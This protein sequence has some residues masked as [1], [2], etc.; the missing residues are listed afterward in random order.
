VPDSAPPSPVTT[1]WIT[2]VLRQQAISVVTSGTTPTAVEGRMIYETDTDALR[3]YDGGGWVRQYEGW[4]SYTPTWGGITIG[5]GAST[6]AY[7]R[8]GGNCLFVARLVL[9]STTMTGPLT[10]NPP[11]NAGSAADLDVCKVVFS[12][13]SATA[14]SVGHAAGA[15]TSS[16]SLWAIN[17]AGTY[18]TTAAITTTIPF[19]WANTDIVF[20]HGEYRMTTRYS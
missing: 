13:T 12:D 18:L 6:G 7:V 1:S 5:S 15:S 19:T 3:L 11:I 2:T 4:Q 9:S 20:V 16:I 17:S 10:V 14:A 8:R